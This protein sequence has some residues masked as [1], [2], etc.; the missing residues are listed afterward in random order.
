MR[1]A[2]ASASS[3]ALDLALAHEVGLSGG[4]EPPRF[5]SER[6]HDPTVG[7]PAME[8]AP[9]H[10]PTGSRGAE[11]P[12][13]AVPAHRELPARN[14]G[15]RPVPRTRQA[16]VRHHRTGTGPRLA[17]ADG[18]PA[19]P[20]VRDHRRDRGRPLR[21]PAHRGNCLRRRSHLL[22]CARGLRRVRADLGWADLRHRLPVRDVSCVRGPGGAGAA[23]QRGTPGSPAAADRVLLDGV[24]AVVD[25]WTHPRRP[26]VRDRPVMAVHR[27]GD[28][29]VAGGGLRPTRAAA[30]LA[31]EAQ[32][33][34]DVPSRRRGLPLH[35]PHADPVRGDR[36]RLVR[37]A[38]RRCGRAVAGDRRRTAGC[39]RGR[40]RVPPRRRAASAQ[41]SPRSSWRGN[42][43]DATSVSSCSSRSVCS[44]GRRSCSVPRLNT[45]WP[46]WR[47]PY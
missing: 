44:V 30:P 28:P 37:G 42:R 1:A 14:G 10:V 36:A 25:L 5:F 24:D 2:A 33:P 9:D 11:R 7:C 16:R 12:F 29:D 4:V 27:C 47:W 35:P 15:H 38:V 19:G 6:A 40:P 39:R 13:G 8:P 22:S 23:R 3:A 18:V 17:R 46:S 34:A 32:G 21:T 41:A 43:C 20:V 45:G 31:G 26:V